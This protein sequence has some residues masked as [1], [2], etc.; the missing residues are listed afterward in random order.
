M[1]T[2]AP[3]ILFDLDGTLVDH[4][5]AARAGA[6]SFGRAHGVPGSDDHLAARWKEIE[7]RW[8]AAFER[9]ELT[10]IGQRVERAREFLGED[11]AEEE[12]LGLYDEYLAAYRGAWRAF[13]DAPGVLDRALAAGRRVGVFTNGSPE[14]QGAKLERTGLRRDAVRLLATTELGAPKP[15][16]ESYRLALA[17]MGVARAGDCLMVGDNRRNDVEKP[18]EAG[19][20]AVY[21]DRTGGEGDIAS[22][23]E[24]EF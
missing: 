19:M 17:A 5:S 23:A 18:R 7:D 6:I 14:M 21:L 3:V 15:Q 1:L 8:F 16:P 10:H 24:L 22:L 4:A 12:A 2:D 13:A 9:G 20:C 11:L